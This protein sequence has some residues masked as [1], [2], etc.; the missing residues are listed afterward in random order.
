MALTQIGN[1]PLGTL[2]DGFLFAPGDPGL[3]PC[4]GVPNF[5]GIDC[6]AY[7]S[8][9]AAFFAAYNGNPQRTGN[10]SFTVVESPEPGTIFLFLS[11]IGLCAVAN[12]RVSSRHRA[13]TEEKGNV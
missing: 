5:T 10:W 12:R 7:G 3:N 13:A 4:P 2:A 11:G 1:D 6:L 9:N 8:V